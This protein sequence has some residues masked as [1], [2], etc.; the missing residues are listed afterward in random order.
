GTCSLCLTDAGPVCGCDGQTYDSV[1]EAPVGVAKAGLCCDDSFAC[2]VG[3][4]VDTDGD[5]CDDTCQCI[6]DS[7]CGS[8][9]VCAPQVCG[10]DVQVCLPCLEDTGFVCGCDGV[11]WQSACAAFKAGVAVQHAGACKCGEGIGCGSPTQYCDVTSCATGS[12]GLCLP[13]SDDDAP[14]CGCDGIVYANTCAIA[15][16]GFDLKTIGAC[17]PQ[18]VPVSCAVDEIAVDTNDDN[19]ADECECNPPSCGAGQVP[20][21]TG[22]NGCADTCVCAPIDCLAWE[23]S[24]VVAGAACPVCASKPCNS[25]ADCGTADAYCHRDVG[26]CGNVGTCEPLSNL[27]CV[28]EEPVCGCDSV[29]YANTCKAFTEAKGVM[30]N[31][32]CPCPDIAFGCEPGFTLED[33]NND[34]CD[35]SCVA[36]PCETNDDCAD[37]SVAYCEHEAG[38]CSEVGACALIPSAC[39]P[40]GAPVCSCSGKTYDNA[41]VAAAA[42]DSVAS[43][44]ACPCSTTA[45]PDSCGSVCN[46]N[47]ECGDNE[48]CAR[49]AES[50]GS[51][52][53]CTGRPTS[54]QIATNDSF[55]GCDGQKYG[56]ACLA[57][58]NGVSAGKANVCQ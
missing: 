11:T 5:G 4:P 45:D 22:Q 15:E 17:E 18:C 28:G 33:T 43:E 52:G 49:S 58:Q 34:S 37:S 3:E 1:C 54:C 44:G 30:S 50:C 21:D 29:T 2:L 57:A 41:C 6:A 36:N 9:Q 20:S 39:A 53:I 46:A 38:K 27:S 32:A 16:V 7:E 14:A 56:N 47:S 10:V 51:D 55:C 19:C 8:G 26:A 23:D 31:G 12:A 24:N 13:C 42:G 25:N 48:Y 35:D 40:D